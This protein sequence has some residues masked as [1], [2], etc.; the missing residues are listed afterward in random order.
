M[1]QFF[2]FCENYIFFKYSLQ[3]IKSYFKTDTHS[4]SER[5]QLRVLLISYIFSYNINASRSGSLLKGHIVIAGNGMSL[6]LIIVP[7]CVIDIGWLFHDDHKSTMS[8]TQ[9]MHAIKIA[10]AQNIISNNRRRSPTYRKPC[11]LVLVLNSLNI[12]IWCSLSWWLNST[13]CLN[14]I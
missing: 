1:H 9:Y 3:P 14:S 2:V 11:I 8:I 7:S 6:T 4:S 10:P 12:L 13:E 5:V